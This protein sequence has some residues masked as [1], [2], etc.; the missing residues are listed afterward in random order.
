[1]F[2]VADDTQNGAAVGTNVDGTTFGAAEAAVRAAIGADT[3]VTITA[4]T[5]AGDGLSIA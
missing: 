4:V 2:A 3:S 1:V 5:P